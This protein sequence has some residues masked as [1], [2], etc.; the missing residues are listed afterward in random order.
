MLD[1]VAALEGF[2][3]EVLGSRLRAL[4]ESAGL[5]LRDVAGRT[6]ISTSA[7]S[8]I[9]R[10]V[11]RPS[12][13]RLFSLVTALDASLVDVFASAGGPP[14]L[15]R[16]VPAGGASATADDHGLHGAG[17]AV[18]RR[19]V[20]QPAVTLAGGVTF[21]RL[22][23]G[24]VHD[25]DFFESTYPPGATAGDA[26]E[27]LAHRG[28]EIGTVTAGELTLDLPDERV[29]LRP[30]DSVSYSCRTPHRLSNRGTETAV[31]TWLIVHPG[32]E[33][34]PA[35]RAPATAPPA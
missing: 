6:G 25:V 7:V 3:A 18:V 9:E 12:V 24:P 2:D 20:E 5:T 1:E 19:A 32:L 29:V 28:Y 10:G 11:L 17:Q 22:S 4:R 26:D 21:R 14:T 33:E 13:H 16:D 27:L 15:P 23:P 8:Q 31:A 30:G 35:L 34:H